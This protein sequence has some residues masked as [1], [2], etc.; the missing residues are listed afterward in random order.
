MRSAVRTLRN[1]SIQLAV[2]LALS[3]CAH[4]QQPTPAQVA[5]ATAKLDAWRKGRQRVYMDDFGELKRYRAA[6]AQLKATRR[7]REARRVLR[8]L[9]HGSVAAG[10]RFPGKPYVNRGISGQTTS[11][12]LVRFRAT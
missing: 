7:G 10:G 11:Q 9:D 2:L 8:R 12:L 5:R 4:G 6:N 1:L 3:A